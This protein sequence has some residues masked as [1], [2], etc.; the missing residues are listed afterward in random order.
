M[1]IKVFEV[2]GWVPSEAAERV[3][4]EDQKKLIERRL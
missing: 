4:A 2:F 1:A 3:L